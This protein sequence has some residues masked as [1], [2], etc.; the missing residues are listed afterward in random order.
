MPALFQT[1]RERVL[2]L[3]KRANQ[4]FLA[5]TKPYQSTRCLFFN[6]VNYNTAAARPYA[7]AVARPNQVLEFFGYGTGDPWIPQ[8]FI[9]NAPVATEAE[10]NLGEGKSTN[11]AQDFVIE[12]VGF[13]CRG[14]R[15]V[16]PA[17]NPNPSGVAFAEGDY[18][19]A[20]Q[21]LDGDVAGALR[22]GVNQVF[23][24]GTIISPPQ[25]F[26]PFNLEQALM[27]SIIGSMSLEF[28]WDKRRIEKIT[29]TDLLPQAGA[30]SYLRANGEPCSGNR[31]RI[32]EG[33]IWRRDGQDDCEFI[34]RVILREPI[35]VPIDLSTLPDAPTVYQTPTLIGLD[36]VM[37]LYGLSCALPSAN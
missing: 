17:V 7:Y 35:V 8:Q 12:G 10:T 29:T 5:N 31:Y 37:R 16:V 2:E 18:V 11:G 27:Q 20:G 34:A 22:D 24:P 9:P 25:M 21:T 26:S 33:Y 1:Q 28:E 30:S 19:A 32:P 3:F 15:I 6:V 13:H 36:L 4:T 14:Q 23:D